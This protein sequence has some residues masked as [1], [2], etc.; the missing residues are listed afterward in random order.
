MVASPIADPGVLSSTLAWSHTL[1]EIDHEIFSTLIL[2]LP[3]I[4]EGAKV[5]AQSTQ[6]NH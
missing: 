1:V 5:C 2:L 4:Q 6:V 3:L